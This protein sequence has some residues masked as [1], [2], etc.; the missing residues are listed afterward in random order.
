MTDQSM[1]Y[2][3]QWW[4]DRD[5]GRV[6]PHF[7]YRSFTRCDPGKWNKPGTRYFGRVFSTGGYF[8]VWHRPPRSDA[9]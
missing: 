7:V 3:Q 6:K 9:T 8:M 2:T 1:P 4:S 5:S